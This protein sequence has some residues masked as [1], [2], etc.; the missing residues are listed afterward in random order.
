MV[1]LLAAEPGIPNG[2][3]VPRSPSVGDSS[4]WLDITPEQKVDRMRAAWLSCH[5]CSEL[6]AACTDAEDVG[7]AV[8]YGVSVNPR[9]FGDI[10]HAREVLGW[11]PKDRTPE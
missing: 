9:Q 11:N 7:W 2:S 8:V 5:D 1:T 3:V 10:S 4:F 6:I